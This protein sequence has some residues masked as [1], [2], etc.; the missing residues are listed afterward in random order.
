MECDWFRLGLDGKGK[1]LLSVGLLA[2][3]EVEVGVVG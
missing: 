2:G 3:V 1:L